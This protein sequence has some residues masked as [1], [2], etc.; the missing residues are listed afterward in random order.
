M[1]LQETL[2]LDWFLVNG[3]VKTV[4]ENVAMLI[5]S[6]II[7]LYTITLT[8]LLL[9][10]HF[11]ILASICHEVTGATFIR[12]QA[13]T[14]WTGQQRLTKLKQLVPHHWL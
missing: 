8:L 9:F 14:P 11:F 13:G 3:L 1:F 5:F 10:I 2:F 12:G 7:M 4:K 6:T